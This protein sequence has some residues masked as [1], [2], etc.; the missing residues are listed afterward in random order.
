MEIRTYSESDQAEVAAL[1]RTVF[2]DSSSWNVP[3]EDIVRKLEV[4]RE[5]FYVALV[6]ETLVG[7]A[8]G[9]YDGHRGWLYYV[10]VHPDYRRQGIGSA[11]VRQVESGL[12]GIG[13]P[14]VNLQVRATNAA[15]VDFYRTLGYESEE[16]LSMGKRLE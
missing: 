9:G 11:L 5:L 6:D 12:A 3:E 13:C 14:K 10:A 4:Q 2:P 8:M 15:V 1:W 7:T 16:R